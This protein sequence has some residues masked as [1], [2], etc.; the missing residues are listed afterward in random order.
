MRRMLSVMAVPP[1]LGVILAKAHCCPG[2]LGV[3][4]SA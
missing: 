4:Q 2:F 1:S 3:S